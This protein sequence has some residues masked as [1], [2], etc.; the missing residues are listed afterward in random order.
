MAMP[1]EAQPADTLLATLRRT[2]QVP[3]D[4]QM[5]MQPGVDSIVLYI[6]SIAD[7]LPA[8]GTQ[9]LRRDRM[10]R[11][12]FLKEPILGSAVAA[13]SSQHASYRWEIESEDEGLRDAVTEMIETSHFGEG[14]TSFVTAL[15]I[16]YLTQDRGAYIEIVREANQPDA[17]VLGIVCLEALR[18]RPTGDPRKPVVYTDEKSQD[19]LLDYWNV[20]RL[21]EM[22]SSIVTMRGMQYSAVSRVL[23]ASQ[24]MRDIIIYRG[25]KVGGR[26]Q[27]MIHIVGGPAKQD[28]KRALQAGAEDADNEGL[29]RF[30]LPTILASLD[31][32]KP[33]SH[34]EIPLASLPD[35]FDLEDEMKSYITTIALAFCRDYQDFGPLPGGNL[36]PS[37]QSEILAA[38]TKGK[39]PALFMRSM[40]YAMNR[41]GIV[42]FPLAIFH[43][44]E[45]DL[46]DEGNK[47]KIRRLRAETRSTMIKSGEITPDVAR[48]LAVK[49]GDYDAELLGE[50]ERTEAEGRE[51]AEQNLRLNAE[52]NAS[53]RQTV[54]GR[55]PGTTT[56]PR[57]PG[58]IAGA[59]KGSA[60]EKG[61]VPYDGGMEPVLHA[62][63]KLMDIQDRTVYR[64]I[65]EIVAALVKSGH[66][67]EELIA[68]LRI[69]AEAQG[70][71]SSGITALT[72]SLAKLA[73]A[74]LDAKT[75]KG[76]NKVAMPTPTVHLELTMPEIEETTKVVR[77]KDGL[78]DTFTK[79]R[80]PIKKEAR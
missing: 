16:D 48:M 8:W 51:R 29:T 50:I 28:I 57:L 11:E 75:P 15:S 64:T 9:T 56:P 18:C 59:K 46:E 65:P 12:F 30:T 23:S 78:V 60:A 24:I 33:V 73:G 27:R 43:Y 25:E 34:V 14:W 54:G 52:V 66:A 37:N 5:G 38:K 36:G 76:I 26:F 35:N 39:G 79:I 72:A 69:S 42:P 17:A 71:T 63:Q 10:L 41:R 32:S 13:V 68:A 31:P 1:I 2:V 74:L 6:A 55:A 67:D 40:E 4:A 20:A 49:D 44:R 47:E 3:P 70:K 77:D 19:H 58:G 7:T 61:I 22:P 80:K 45:Q 62:L 53:V 21:V